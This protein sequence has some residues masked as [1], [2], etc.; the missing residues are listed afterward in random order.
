[1][2]KCIFWDIDDTLIQGNGASEHILRQ[3]LE[4]LYGVPTQSIDLTGKTDL[5]IIRALY[6]TL[7]TLPDVTA[8]SAYV[9]T[10]LDTLAQHAPFLLE[11]ATVQV[12]VLAV[13]AALAPVALQSV[14]TGN[15]Q[16][17]AAY[18]L[19]LFDLS[20]W[21]DLA[22]GGYGSDHADRTALVPI[23]LQRVA[24]R[25]GTQFTGQDVVVIGDTPAD[26]ACG[27]AA[28]ARTV[29]VATGSWSVAALRDA[30]ADVVLSNLADT[31]LVIEA[32][33]AH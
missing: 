10:Y 22:V 9:Q 4:R 25:Y 12:G 8:T 23:A 26:V 13:L 32:I 16:P 21:F 17:I 3:T 27:Q 24:E 11:H 18:K 1:M 31:A 14:V 6:P 30:G 15:V 28:G 2:Q 7:S 33:L 19:A 29:A 5:Q 20:T